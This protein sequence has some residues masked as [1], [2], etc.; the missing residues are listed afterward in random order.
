MI[1][2]NIFFTLDGIVIDINR[3][4]TFLLENRYVVGYSPRMDITTKEWKYVFNKEKNFFKSRL[5]IQEALRASWF[6]QQFSKRFNV[7][8]LTFVPPENTFPNAK[9]QREEFCD[10]YLPW[11]TPEILSYKDYKNRSKMYRS[12]DIVIDWDKQIIDKCYVK[13]VIGHHLVYTPSVDF[14][15]NFCKMF[16]SYIESEVIAGRA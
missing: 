16:G 1:K 3:P 14:S 15:K 10:M 12:G 8:F 7:R 11:L 6:V 2:R 4:L 5:F 13:G 9:E